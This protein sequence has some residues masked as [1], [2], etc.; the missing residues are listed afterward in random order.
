[1]HLGNFPVFRKMGRAHQ[2]TTDPSCNV[3]YAASL[4]GFGL[5]WIG[6]APSETATRNRLET[7][8]LKFRLTT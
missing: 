7:C 8:D 4:A 3:C 5:V 2:A 1:M 6:C